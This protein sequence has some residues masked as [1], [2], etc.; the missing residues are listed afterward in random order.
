MPG[1]NASVTFDFKSFANYSD[2]Y[3]PRGQLL[4]F[5]VNPYNGLVVMGYQS[6]EVAMSVIDDLLDQGFGAQGYI[7][8]MTDADA[9]MSDFVRYCKGD[10]VFDDFD[11]C[12]FCGDKPEYRDGSIT[13]CGGH[14][15]F[16]VFDSE[17]QAIKAWNGRCL[18]VARSPKVVA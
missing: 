11:D 5:A 10:L 6:G 2:D 8:A 16:G 12:P 3:F 1:T 4:T 9:G 18:F 14:L 13:C 7:S 17:R 15:R